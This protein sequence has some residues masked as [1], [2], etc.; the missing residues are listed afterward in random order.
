MHPHA[1]NMGHGSWNFGKMG[2]STMS[3]S[4]SLT[5]G[6]GSFDFNELSM[7]Q[8][9]VDYFSLLPNRGVSPTANL[10]VDLSRN[11]HIDRRQVVVLMAETFDPVKV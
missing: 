6:S 11:F 4:G 1:P 9:G 2:P 10:A 5:F 7:R 3:S 8:S